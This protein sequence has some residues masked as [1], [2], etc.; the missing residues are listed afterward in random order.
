[1]KNKVREF[2]EKLHKKPVHVRRTIL[3]ISTASITG[4]IFIIWLT[5]WSVLFNPPKSDTASTL[6]IATPVFLI[7]D[8]WQ[9]FRD[10]FSNS[11]SGLKKQL[12]IGNGD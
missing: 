2:L 11:F 12:K 4:I 3:L 9:G 7:K 8:N 6:N 5:S 10:S 1:M